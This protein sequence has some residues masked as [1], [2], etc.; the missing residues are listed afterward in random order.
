MPVLFNSKASL[1]FRFQSLFL[2][3]HLKTWF[4]FSEINGA[5][6]CSVTAWHF[7]DLFI[8][9][10]FLMPC[11]ISLQYLESFLRNVR[12]EGT[13]WVMKYK[14]LTIAGNTGRNRA[15]TE[16]PTEVRVW[17]SFSCTLPFQRQWRTSHIFNIWEMLYL[18]INLK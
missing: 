4:S 5:K 13:I 16:R 7:K 3:L 10:F 14:A 15:G 6:T 2:K 18:M 11:G 1:I 12:P 17:G 8:F 9:F